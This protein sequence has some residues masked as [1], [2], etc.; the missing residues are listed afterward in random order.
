MIRLE[1]EL[2]L[3][4]AQTLTRLHGFL[5]MMKE[6]VLLF[7]RMKHG[8]IFMIQLDLIVRLQDM[9]VVGIIL[10]ITQHICV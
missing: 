9:D 6:Y 10:E 3:Q 5:K 4:N 2:V 8:V 7:V 1:I